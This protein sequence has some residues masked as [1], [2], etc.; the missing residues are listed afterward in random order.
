[1]FNVNTSAKIDSYGMNTVCV[2]HGEIFVPRLFGRTVATGG[3]TELN[4]KTK[5]LQRRPLKEKA[6]PHLRYIYQKQI[7]IYDRN[8]TYLDNM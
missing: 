3:M 4:A 1:M 7:K 8:L 2:N 6:I 5:S